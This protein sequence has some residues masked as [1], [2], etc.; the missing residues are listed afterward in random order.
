MNIAENLEL[1]HWVGGTY[2]LWIDFTESILKDKQNLSLEVGSSLYKGTGPFVLLNWEWE[3]TFEYNSTSYTRS[4]SGKYYLSSAS[5]TIPDFSIPITDANRSEE[6]VIKVTSFKS[7]FRSTLYS[8]V[9]YNT[10]LSRFLSKYPKSSII[11]RYYTTK[12]NTRSLKEVKTVP[13]HPIQAEGVIE[14]FGYFCSV[15]NTKEDGTGTT[16]NTGDQIYVDDILQK[17]YAT[18]YTPIKY[19]INLVNKYSASGNTE[20]ALWK[21]GVDYDSL[22][23]L[24]NGLESIPFTIPDDKI[25]VGWTKTEDSEA[26]DYDDNCLVMNI[27]SK[28][29]E[30]VSL[31]TVIKNKIYTLNY[32]HGY[33]S[34]VSYSIPS[35]VNQYFNDTTL[36]YQLPNPL[37]ETSYK[38]DKWL[39][40]RDSRFVI[41][42]ESLVIMR[43]APESDWN[44]LYTLI[45]NPIGSTILCAIIAHQSDDNISWQSPLVI[46]TDSELV[47]FQYG[48]NPYAILHYAGSLEY[49]GTT[50]YYALGAALKFG[51]SVTYASDSSKM[52]RINISEVLGKIYTYESSET[53]T[54]EIGSAATKDL[55]DLYYNGLE[56]K[57]TD[58]YLWYNDQ[59]LTAKWNIAENYFFKMNDVWKSCLIYRK[60][61]NRWVRMYPYRKDSTK[62][63]DFGIKFVT[64]MYYNMLNT[65]SYKLISPSNKF[66]RRYSYQQGYDYVDTTMSN[67]SGNQ[68]SL[69]DD[70][71]INKDVPIRFD[72]IERN[73]SNT[74]V[75]N[76]INIYNREKLI[77]YCN[78]NTENITEELIA[79]YS[80][81]I[82]LEDDN[83][84]VIASGLLDRRISINAKFRN[85]KNSDNDYYPVILNGDN[86]HNYDDKIIIEVDIYSSTMDI[87]LDS[88]YLRIPYTYIK[89]QNRTIVMTYEKDGELRQAISTNVEFGSN[90]RNRL[91]DI[92]NVSDK[93]VLKS[94]ITPYNIDNI[95]NGFL[96]FLIICGDDLNPSID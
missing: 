72:L 90:N 34:L 25:F 31:Y 61:N 76:K 79:R 47:K 33:D 45:S 23:D 9:Y 92:F 48:D 96:S 44:R 80:I 69:P 6:Q 11:L 55:L 15:W 4:G 42:N 91:S 27:G 21:S 73:I 22:I 87:N 66:F 71:C 36:Q 56:L 41:S 54:T 46:S 57:S 20:Q 43:L 51:D 26:I 68:V 52:Y 77:S 16:Y 59:T 3:I 28:D 83:D 14:G 7:T 10:S 40:I 62:W 95:N 35:R 88:I 58:K 60:M 64:R 78:L 74:L 1:N 86:I 17:V 81:Q 2:N 82:I 30:T 39:S 65:V 29:G 24:P 84:N 50:W 32:D 70:F 93:T 49:N 8:G 37:R 53:W 75:N 67:S 12:H 5:A 94:S 85:T 38:F 13:T 19:N 18:S 63:Y 89:S